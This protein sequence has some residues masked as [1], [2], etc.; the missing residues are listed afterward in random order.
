MR[1]LIHP[2]V[3]LNQLDESLLLPG[4][5]LVAQL[6]ES[7]LRQGRDLAGVAVEEA[8][9]G[10][11]LAGRRQL[12]RWGVVPGLEFLDQRQ[13]P[14]PCVVFRVVV[15]ALRIAGAE[16]R[17]EFIRLGLL[18]RRLARAELVFEERVEVGQIVGGLFVAHGHR[19]MSLGGN[20]SSL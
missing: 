6:P 3:G 2:V 13:L 11:F 5:G 7:H 17:R 9:P 12:L 4:L 10:I 16:V 1:Q 18:A 15:P 19:L 20:S 14:A 8:E